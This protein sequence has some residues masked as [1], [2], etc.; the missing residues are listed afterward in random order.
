MPASTAST[1]STGDRARLRKAARR[2][3]PSRARMSFMSGPSGERGSADLSRRGGAVERRASSAIGRESVAAA[4]SRAP[5]LRFARVGLPNRPAKPIYGHRLWPDDW[6]A[7]PSLTAWRTPRTFS[8]KLDEPG[9]RPH[10]ALE[11]HVHLEVKDD[12]NDH[13]YREILQRSK[14][15]RLHPARRW[16]QGRFRPCDGPRARR[17]PRPRR[18]PE[19]DLRHRRGPPLRQDCGQHHPDRAR[20][21]RHGRGL[22]PV[23]EAA[24]TGGFFIS[25][26]PPPGGRE[27]E[28]MYFR[29]STPQKSVMFAV[30]FDD[31]RTAYMVVE[32]HGKPSD[33]YLAGSIAKERQDK[34]ELPEGTITTIKRVR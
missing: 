24:F 10:R 20:R 28:S 13:G 27:E 2:L 4:S 19:G 29:R 15:L 31:G 23:L 30:N 33:D 7:S 3:A 11:A 12:R 25:R 16:R 26:L 14:R 17:H 32:N 1:T 5:E 21:S 9:R 6:A 18:R 8:P 34:G 22:G